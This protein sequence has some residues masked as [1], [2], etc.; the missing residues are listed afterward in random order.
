MKCSEGTAEGG[1]FSQIFTL[2]ISEN[3]QILYLLLLLSNGL[4]SFFVSIRFF[5]YTVAYSQNI[6]PPFSSYRHPSTRS[7]TICSD[8]DRFMCY[9]VVKDV[10]YVDRVIA[11]VEEEGE[12]RLHSESSTFWSIRKVVYNIRFICANGLSNERRT[13]HAT[14][15]HTHSHTRAPMPCYATVRS[16][17]TTYD[18]LETHLATQ[19]VQLRLVAVYSSLWKLKL[20]YLLHI[21][22]LILIGCGCELWQPNLS[23]TFLNGW[24]VQTKIVNVS[25]S[26]CF[27]VCVCSIPFSAI[28]QVGAHSNNI[29]C[30]LYSNWIHWQV[31]FT[32]SLSECTWELPHT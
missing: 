15:I 22:V 29:R 4:R 2:Q 1:E 23:N 30:W 6:F 8:K 26:H 13:L 9:V 20:R 25:S 7:H 12:T 32:L 27:S 16:T 5:C 11:S 19:P 18:W 28:S 10:Y 17:D 31:S 3:K 21:F 14:S 24:I